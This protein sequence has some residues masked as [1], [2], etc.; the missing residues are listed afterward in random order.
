MNNTIHDFYH[1]NKMKLIKNFILNSSYQLLLIIL[2]LI[3]APYISRV[4]GAHGVGIYAFTGANVQYFILFAVLG[5]AT[6]GN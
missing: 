3:T 1:I 6:Y 5:T 2:P 4:I